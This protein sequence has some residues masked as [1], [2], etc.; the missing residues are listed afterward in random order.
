VLLAS[1]NPDA[2][3]ELA[4]YAGVTSERSVETAALVHI[5]FGG[6]T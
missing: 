1:L 2:V 3:A 6:E 5:L 4:D